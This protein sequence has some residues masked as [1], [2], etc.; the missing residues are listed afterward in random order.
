M[1]AL[2]PRIKSLSGASSPGFTGVRAAART[3]SAYS[4]ELGC[5]GVNCNPTAT[6]AARDQ[7]AS[8]SKPDNSTGDSSPERSGAR[9]VDQ[10]AIAA[11]GGRR[12][13]SSAPTSRLL[14]EFRPSLK[15]GDN[16]LLAK[17]PSAANCGRAVARDSHQA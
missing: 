14:A 12:I 13:P 8:G 3:G 10:G 6:L 2:E 16:D 11:S 15:K 1:R 9:V 5:T 17:L 7:P 4:N